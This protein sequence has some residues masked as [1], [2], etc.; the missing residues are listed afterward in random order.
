MKWQKT[1]SKRNGKFGSSKLAISRHSESREK[2][3]SEESE[4]LIDSLS[5][6]LEIG[7]IVFERLLFERAFYSSGRAKFMEHLLARLVA[8]L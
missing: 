5:F 7:K 6:L 2:D 1:F 8:Y 4:K 3:G